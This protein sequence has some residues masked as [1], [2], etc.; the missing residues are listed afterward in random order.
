M[1]EYLASQL[2]R[3]RGLPWVGDIRGMGLLQVVEFV[4]NQ[5]TREPS[6]PDLKIFKRL[7]AELRSRGIIVYPGS[8]TVD[9]LIGD[10]ILIAPPFIIEAS[11]I[12]WLVDQ[13]WEATSV[14]CD[15]AGSQKTRTA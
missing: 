14:V 6:A 7:S 5:K 3:L 15:S 12:D 9:G 10:H 1:G 2:A 8:G 4:Q 13:I 11:Q